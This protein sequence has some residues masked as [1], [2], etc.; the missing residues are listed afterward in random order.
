MCSSISSTISIPRLLRP[1][2]MRLSLP[3]TRSTPR[4]TNYKWN[5]NPSSTCR[6]KS[7]ISK[8]RWKVWRRNSHEEEAATTIY[9]PI[10]KFKICISLPRRLSYNLK[11]IERPSLQWA[12]IPHSQS[13]P[14][15]RKMGRSKSGRLKQETSAKLYVGIQVLYTYYFR[16]RELGELWQ[17][18]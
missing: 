17:D 12:S 4:A 10:Q 3:W 14:P 16:Q 5:G 2:R 8:I 13:W 9:Q 1:S 7:T 15:A 6:R 18:G 11:A